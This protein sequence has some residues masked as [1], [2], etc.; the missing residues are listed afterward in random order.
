MISRRASVVFGVAEAVVALLV[1]VGVFAAL[2]ARWAPVDVVAGAL[3]LLKVASSAGLLADRSWAR[4]AAVASAS[5]AL[6][7]GL[8]V[9]TGLGLAAGWLAGIYGS[10]GA[11]GALM[12][13]LVA[14]LVVPYLVVLPA[15]Q[16]GWLLPGCDG[17]R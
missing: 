4:A 14:A 8:F 13:G 2:P 5:A 12:F 17:G 10:V 9:V 6:A 1:G 11:G 15:V 3:V 16:L 7:L